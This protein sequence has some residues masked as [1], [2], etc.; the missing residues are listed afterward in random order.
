MRWQP[1]KNC[2]ES[3]A[4][5]QHLFLGRGDKGREGGRG[6]ISFMV[7]AYLRW[8]SFFVLIRLQSI[9][10][11]SERF[12]LI[13]SHFPPLDEFR[14][15]SCSPP[16]PWTLRP[17]VLQAFTL[18]PYFLMSCRLASFATD[19]ET[20]GCRS[21]QAEAWAK[22]SRDLW[23]SI[24]E[25]TGIFFFSLNIFCRSFSQETHTRKGGRRRFDC[26]IGLYHRAHNRGRA[27]STN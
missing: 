13:F 10:Q 25:F 19:L 24:K 17:G 7:L 4:E 3:F 1:S 14:P 9:T 11:Y 23:L 26:M 8:S 18:R 20:L 16:F 12:I 2:K 6:A 27:K 21:L 15:P 5:T 22:F